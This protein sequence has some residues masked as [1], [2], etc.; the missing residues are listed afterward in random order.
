MRDPATLT[1]H[2]RNPNRHG[3]RQIELLAKV[4]RHQGWRNPIV[5]SA[6]SGF[7]IAGHG[8]LAAARL[9]GVDEVPVDVQDFETEADEWAH[10]VADNRIAELAEMDDEGL[11]EIL[12]DLGEVED[13]ELEWSGFD[14]EALKDLL[15]GKDEV[16]AGSTSPCRG[17][18]AEFG[19]APFSV[20][21]ARSGPWQDRKR[22]WIESGIASEEGRD[23]D[24]TFATS[25]QPQATYEKK[26]EIEAKDGRPLSWQEFA[27]RFPEA[28]QQSGTSIF[29]PVLAEL[30][31]RWWCPAGGR[32]LDPFAGGSVRGLVAA[33]LGLHYTGVDLRPEQVEA[34]ERQAA[35]FGAVEGSARWITGDS[36]NLPEL[37]DGEECFDF[38][39]S[40]PPYYDLEVYSDRPEDLS[41]AGDYAGF[42]EAYREII[43]RACERLAD[44][45]FACW[46]I[47]DVR[48]KRGWFHGLTMDTVRA[49]EDAGMRLYNDAILLTPAGSLPM[50]VR[51]QFE[52]S[53]KLGKTHQYVL[54]FGKGEPAKVAAR[55]SLAVLPAE[56]QE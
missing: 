52:K 20:F 28:M 22:A 36:R 13:F 16:P 12:R 33:K 4:I 38:M 51:G 2:P 25:S 14:D 49:F 6:R 3:Q 1:D 35:A 19:A 21:D 24:L 23:G 30:A 39:L 47:G 26:A 5:V 9:L 32:V 41:A 48:D 8:R 46:V 44:D 54:I 40:C 17:L 18:V 7:V 29:D 56:A 53:R 10:L 37:V 31:L 43:A 45:A 11:G 34:N 50:R 55:C 27:E 42:L 15:G